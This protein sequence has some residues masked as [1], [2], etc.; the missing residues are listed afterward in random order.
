MPLSDRAVELLRAHA[1]DNGEHVFGNGKPLSNMALLEMLRGMAGNGYTVHGF[2]AA[3]PIGPR[4][5]GV[6]A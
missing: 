1:G 3:F 5:H 2:R 6:A 4:S